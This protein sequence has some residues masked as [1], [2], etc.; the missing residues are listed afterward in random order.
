MTVPAN[1]TATVT[2][3]ISWYLPNRPSY[4][5]RKNLP[6]TL[7]NMYQNWFTDA[8]DCAKQYSANSASL[9]ATTREFRDIMYGSSVPWQFT[10]TAA[11]RLA[12]MR[13]PTM[14][15]TKEGWVLGNEGNNCCP[16][17]CSHVYGYVTLL[18][19]LYPD[20]AK[21]M[22]VSD[23][24]RNYDVTN[25]CTM[26]FGAGGFAIDG[27][28]A[29]VIKT[30]LVVRQDDPEGKWLPTVWPNVK[31][32]MELGF[33]NFDTAG[34]GMFRC[35]QQN[36]Y[37]TAMQGPNTFIGSYWVVA[38]KATAA[39]AAMMGDADYAKK[40]AD[41]AVLSAKNYEATCW[42]DKFGYYIA[43]VTAANS[44]HSYGPGCFIDQ[45]CAIGLSTACGMGTIFDPAHE[46]L[47]RKAILKYNKVTKPP[48]QD[49]Q[50][51]FYDGD[52]GVTVC[53]YPNGKLGNGMQ[54]TTLVSI[55]FTYPV[56]AGMIYDRNI[57][58]ATTIA[59]MIR[60]RHDGR[61]RSPWNEPE[62]G[63]LYSR[64]MAGWN[65][66]DQACGLVYD[67]TTGHMGF[68]PRSDATKFNCFVSA[69]GGWG[70]F[71]QT[72][73][74]GLA[75]GTAT[76]RAAWGSISLKTLG[77]VSTATH[78]S[79]SIDGGA[80]TPAVVTKGVVSFGA[81]AVTLKTGSILTVTLAS[82][83]TAMAVPARQTVQECCPGGTCR[84]SDTDGGLRQRK[85]KE[86]EAE[87]CSLSQAMVDEQQAKAAGS[88][89]FFRRAQLIIAALLVLL[90]GIWLGMNLDHSVLGDH[91]SGHHGGHHGDHHGDH[92]MGGGMGSGS[93]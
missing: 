63:L 93:E 84:P 11:G 17:N 90:F 83:W 75:S 21:D 25:G 13:S 37:D 87:A 42:N 4:S 79:F 57:E 6:S 8:T 24:V 50:K 44:A 41:R 14:W 82:A 3:L 30:W 49:L 10:E 38:L 45:L 35:E 58:D 69:S 85:Q 53:S 28:L 12:C 65:L 91:H 16:L 43:D 74:A 47:A 2:F 67:S 48:F 5:A 51:H 72:G 71:T 62:C 26:R 36:T 1:G 34:D 40:C 52:S 55:G 56:V 77:L 73:P 68:D 9:L 60:A 31:A 39:M 29:N 54:Y 23:F 27:S 32:M 88:P 15:W 18:E 22:R 92:A 61:N 19:K 80:S 7:G 76:L 59:G 81:Q 70:E 86:A 20:L 46:A 66:F 78:A 89:S 33:K 64:A